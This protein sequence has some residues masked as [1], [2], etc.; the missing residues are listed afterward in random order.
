MQ[1][2]GALAPIGNG[3]DT[4]LNAS[5]QRFKSVGNIEYFPLFAKA[6][7]SRNM[8]NILEPIFIGKGVLLQKQY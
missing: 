2:G 8:H 3:D 6:S 7:R 4:I 1:D 5:L